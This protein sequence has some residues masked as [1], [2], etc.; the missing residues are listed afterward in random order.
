MKLNSLITNVYDIIVGY[1][2]AGEPAYDI[3]IR[4]C[5]RGSK[6][7]VSARLG[8][9]YFFGINKEV[10]L[11]YIREALELLLKRGVII[12]SMGSYNRLC[13]TPRD[14]DY[15]GRRYLFIRNNKEMLY[16]KYY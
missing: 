14:K 9:Y 7:P 2:I 1:Y 6:G 11:A 5:L 16:E 15:A 4:T 8:D 10:D 13:Y 12:S 3:S